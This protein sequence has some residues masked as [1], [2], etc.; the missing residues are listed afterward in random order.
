M[1]R[2]NASLKPKDSTVMSTLYH[3]KVEGVTPNLRYDIWWDKNKPPNLAGSGEPDKQAT[4]I[5]PVMG[6][7]EHGFFDPAKLSERELRIDKQYLPF[8]DAAFRNENNQVVLPDSPEEFRT[9]IAG[10]VPW[11]KNEEGAFSAEDEAASQKLYKM[12]IADAQKRAAQLFKL[13]TPYLK[14]G[15]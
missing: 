5:F 12:S 2:E 3:S 8:F 10:I 1:L 11:K 9:A 14:T 15:E 4:F 13:L 6:P 7:G